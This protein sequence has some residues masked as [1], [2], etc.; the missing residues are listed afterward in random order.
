[1]SL[2]NKVMIENIL[3]YTAIRGIF[4]VTAPGWSKSSQ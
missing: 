4:A 3:L 2:L 1:M